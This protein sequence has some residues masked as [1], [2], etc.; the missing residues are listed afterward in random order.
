MGC[1]PCP[2]YINPSSWQVQARQ[3]LLCAGPD[4]ICRWS[5]QH[6]AQSPHHYVTCRRS[7]EKPAR[8]LDHKALTSPLAFSCNVAAARLLVG[9]LPGLQAPVAVVQ[10]PS[11]WS[12]DLSKQ[13]PCAP[14]RASPECVQVQRLVAVLT[15]KGVSRS[16]LLEDS[17]PV[18]HEK[19]SVD[20][21]VVL[22][23]AGWREGATMKSLLNFSGDA[24]CLH[25]GPCAGVKRLPAA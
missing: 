7:S 3:D 4:D 10:V 24:A 6:T 11:L 17:T 22:E 9:Y 23:E 18:L 2:I 21:R 20:E 14:D 13:C 15:V 8:L 12:A 25:G 19:L 16:N 1:L 5:L